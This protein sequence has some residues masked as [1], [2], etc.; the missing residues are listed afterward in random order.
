MGN[1]WSSPFGNC[2]NILVYLLVG[3]NNCTTLMRW[4]KVGVGP[5]TALLR[6]HHRFSFECR[7][8]WISPG[9]SL[10]YLPSPVI[11]HL[12]YLSLPYMSLIFLS[13]TYGTDL[14][15]WGVLLLVC[16]VSVVSF[17]AL[18]LKSQSKKGRMAPSTFSLFFTILSPNFDFVCFTNAKINAQF[19]ATFALSA[20]AGIKL[21]L[22]IYYY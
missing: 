19:K 11:A 6:S 1:H 10:P 12:S 13:S 20:S 7:Y 21:L 4:W 3:N 2:P 9:M 16:R 18:S 14:R 8:I 5:S 17:R 15:F 22:L